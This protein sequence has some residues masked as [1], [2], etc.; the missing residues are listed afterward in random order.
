M[1]EQEEIDLWIDL[2]KLLK[3]YGPSVFESLSNDLSAQETSEKLSQILS[4]VSKNRKMVSKVET[5]KTNKNT[6]TTPKNLKA[7]ENV[8]PEKFELLIKFYELLTT[9]TILPTLRE[10]KG[11]AE[12]LNLPEIHADSR[13]K[14]VNSLINAIAILP[15]DK[16]E[17]KIETMKARHSGDHTLEG[18]T[19]IILD[20]KVKNSQEE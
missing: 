20:R 17:T 9:K 15:Y 7:L 12:E 8:D 19:K 13:Q 6:I 1:I 18:W 10:I 14:A 2:L 3:K 11:V 16:I 5:R 4:N